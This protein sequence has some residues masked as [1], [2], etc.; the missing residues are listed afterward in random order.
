LNAATTSNINIR[1][2]IALQ[3]LDGIMVTPSSFGN[4]TI[5]KTAGSVIL[6]QHIDCKGNL[7]TITPG[8]VLYENATQIHF[9]GNMTLANTTLSNASA[10]GYIRAYG[11]NLQTINQGTGNVFMNFYVDKTAGD[12]TLLS[13]MGV[14]YA[15]YLMWGKINTNAFK[16]TYY[17]L[18]AYNFTN[19]NKNSYINGNLKRM[20]Y[21]AYGAGYNWCFPVGTATDYR[22]AEITNTTMTGPTYFDAKYV[23]P[24]TNTGALNPVT[25]IDAV[26][27]TPYVGVSGIWQIDPN[28]VPTGNY[29][30]KLWFNGGTSGANPFGLLD[31]NFGPLKRP[32]SSTLASDW[33]AFTGS[34]NAAGTAGRTIAGGYAQRSGWT[35]F[36]HFGIGSTNVPLPVELAEFSAKC[37]ENVAHISWT[38]ASETNNDYFTIERSKDGNNYEMV[39]TLKGAGNSNS[40]KHYTYSDKEV[41]EGISYYRI[42]QTDFDGKFKYYPSKSVNCTVEAVASVVYYPNPFENELSFEVNNLITPKASIDIVDMLGNIV[43][44]K[45]YE[46]IRPDNNSFTISLSQ[47]AAGTY[48]VRFKSDNFNYI[49]KVFKN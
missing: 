3:S 2:T 38:T 20:Y 7:T 17:A 31:N 19:Y 13:D 33:T 8:I 26:I 45:N 10:N 27:G 14:N 36:S 49:S 21:P 15:F 6:N 43:M 34:L 18:S 5:D 47:L 48:F 41:F 9:A 23:S 37:A 25:A 39:A 42:K 4:L 29:D 46:D 1:G 44:T 16:V 30:I 22:L 24:F 12:I 28:V 35:S 40:P 32:S 11:T